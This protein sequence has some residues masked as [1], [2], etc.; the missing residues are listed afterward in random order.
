VPRNCALTC[1]LPVRAARCNA[2]EPSPYPTCA[3]VSAAV[4][5]TFPAGRHLLDLARVFDAAWGNFADLRAA[6]AGERLQVSV[7]VRSP[8]CRLEFTPPSIRD[9]LESQPL[10]GLVLPLAACNR[11]DVGNSLLFT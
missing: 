2:I 10:S 1:A 9:S 6:V 4:I 11:I 7:K 3:S 5:I 8:S